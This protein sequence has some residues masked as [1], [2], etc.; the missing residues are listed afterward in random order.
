MQGGIPQGTTMPHTARPPHADWK[1]WLAQKALPLWSTTGYDRARN[2]YHERLTLD[3]AP[4]TLPHLRLMV[5]ARQIAT[6]CRAA[7]DGV[8]NA[9]Q[10]ALTCLHTVQKRYW[11]ADGQPGWVFA[12]GPD[13]QPSSTLRDLY[14]HAFI[15]YA[16]AWAYQLTADKTILAVARQTTLEIEQIF[17]APHGGY[18]DTLP[19]QDALHRQNPHMHL[20]EAYLALY[21]VT[22]DSFYLERAHSLIA[23]AQT[24]FMPTQTGMLLEFFKADWA[25]CNPL[26]QNDVEPGHL[27]EWA[28]LLRD[29]IR[30]NPTHDDKTALKALSEQLFQTGLHHGVQH[31]CVFDSMTD[32][33]TLRATSTRIWPQT[34]LMRLL[35]D[36]QRNIT[37][38]TQARRE[39]TLLAGLTQKFFTTYIPPHLQGGWIDRCDANAN[40]CVDH[41]PASSLYYI[42][43]AG[44]ENLHHNKHIQKGK[45]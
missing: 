25:A 31:F 10:E 21:E 1:D 24:R 23:L 42:Y 18:H 13:G 12:L 4:I 38:A 29:A 43:G 40:P 30:L 2:L 27:F 41:M 20:L 19:P 45:K 7:L 3:A 6:F 44:R 32:T 5:Q 35:A 39:S 15:L 14:A 22:A 26:G 37:N 11:Q 17:A 34:E 8:F 16:H 36:R 33:G 9:T 28:W